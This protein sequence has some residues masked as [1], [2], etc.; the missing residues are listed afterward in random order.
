MSAATVRA[1][2][3]GHLAKDLGVECS[4]CHVEG[5]WRDSSNAKWSIA[6]N[7]MRMVDALNVAP[8]AN[9]VGVSCVTCHRGASK[10]T[11]T[12]RTQCYM[13]HKGARKI[14]R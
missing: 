9:T 2:T 8:L 1:Q 3:P 6:K 10:P 4:F 11:P 13:C 5:Q 12:A 7:M 14:T